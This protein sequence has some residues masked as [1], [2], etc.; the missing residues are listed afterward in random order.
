MFDNRVMCCRNMTTQDPMQDRTGMFDKTSCRVNNAT[1]SPRLQ[2]VRLVQLCCIFIFPFAHAVETRN[3]A[4]VDSDSR[5]QSCRDRAEAVA[6]TSATDISVVSA[7]NGAVRVVYIW[8]VKAASSTIRK[9]LPSIGPMF[10]AS[11]LRPGAY[12]PILLIKSIV[13]RPIWNHLHDDADAGT[14]TRQLLLTQLLIHSLRL[15]TRDWSAIR[16]GAALSTH[17]A[18]YRRR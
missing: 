9:M 7:R 8:N 1:R 4:A 14:C 2:K 16:E 13:L 6:Q 11:I 12:V 10:N 5:P 15:Q 17:H 18:L 3:T